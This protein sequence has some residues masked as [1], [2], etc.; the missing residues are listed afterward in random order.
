LVTILTGLAGIGYN[1]QKG[2]K[3]RGFMFC[4]ILVLERKISWS[5]NAERKN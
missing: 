1:K 5:Q 4:W 2:E 3:I